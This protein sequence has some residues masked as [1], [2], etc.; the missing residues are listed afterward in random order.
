[1]ADDELVC[2]DEAFD[3]ENC[4]L[5]DAYI[6]ELEPHL[7]K[8][9]A[10]LVFGY[11]PIHKRRFDS[12]STAFTFEAPCSKKCKAGF[13][14]SVDDKSESQEFTFPPTEYDPDCEVE[15]GYAFG[16]ETKVVCVQ[17]IGNV[18]SHLLLSTETK[19][20]VVV[21]DDNKDLI[22]T[23]SD[24]IGRLNK[25]LTEPNAGV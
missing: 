7:V 5:E 17:Y 8:D 14:L 11:L 6:K 1:M 4:D 18:T 25:S 24:S 9:I 23:I 15:Q 20:R 12:F 21:L 19:S 10:R 16:D 13:T 3:L 22:K 2:D